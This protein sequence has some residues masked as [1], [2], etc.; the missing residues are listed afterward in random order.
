[1][2]DGAC[3][4][5]IDASSIFLADSDY[6]DSDCSDKDK[7]QIYFSYTCEVDEHELYEKYLRMAKI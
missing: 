6:E 4:I 1:M 7:S 5:N 3:Q 2:D